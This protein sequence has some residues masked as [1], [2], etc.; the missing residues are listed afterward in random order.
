MDSGDVVLTLISPVSVATVTA[1]ADGA[2]AFAVLLP[3]TAGL[4]GLAGTAGAPDAGV[5]AGAGAEAAG[6]V[7]SGAGWTA[8]CCGALPDPQLARSNMAVAEPAAMANR[9][10][11]VFII[12]EYNAR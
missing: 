5:W 1:G 4:A 3:E 10:F 2:D 9:D 8:V 6:A 12:Q 7:W 11:R